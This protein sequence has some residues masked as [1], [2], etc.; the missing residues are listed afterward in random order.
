MSTLSHR[1]AKTIG[2]TLP[3][4]ALLAAVRLLRGDSHLH[5][6][7]WFKSALSGLP[8]DAHGE[9]LPW[10]SYAAIAFLGPRVTREMTV[11]EYGSGQSTLWW[12]AR[13]G[14]VT[15]CEHDA[16]WFA[17]MRGRIPS[18]VRYEHRALGD[19]GYAKEITSAEH[20]FDVVVIDGRER[21]ACA[22]AA[23][24]ALTPGGVI[25]W[26]NSDRERYASGYAHLQQ[27]GFKRLD[28]WGMGPV[29]TDGWCTSVFYRHANVLGI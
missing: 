27:L 11:F 14:S 3:G 15:S 26:D 5:S 9:A 21:V 18:N 29:N 24:A 4:S 13:A 17:R 25:V 1:V 7:G 8:Q 10:Y 2:S 12:A 6:S 20:P 23:A 16:G 19:G 22:R 28:F